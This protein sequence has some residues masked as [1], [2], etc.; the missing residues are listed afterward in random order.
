MD[1]KYP[2]GKIQAVYPELQT[3]KKTQPAAIQKFDNQIIGGLKVPQNLLNFIAGQHNGNI[4]S[5]FGPDKTKI[6]P[7]LHVIL[8]MALRP[9]G[10]HVL[11]ESDEGIGLLYFSFL[12]TNKDNI[13][14]SIGIEFKV[15]HHK[16]IKHGINRQLPAYLKSIRSQCGSFVVMWFKDKKYFKEPENRNL[17]QMTEW[18]KE[19]AQKVSAEFDI[20]VVSKV[21]DA[22]IRPSASSEYQT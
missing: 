21:I 11:R 19:E 22:S 7:T 16:K 9:F 2:F 20:T 3:F 10:I 8:D 18:L 14:F 4:R 6:Q 17:E 12:Y 1:G 5:F 13:P 15:A